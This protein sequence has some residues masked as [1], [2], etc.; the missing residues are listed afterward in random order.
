MRTPRKSWLYAAAV[1]MALC[2][3]AGAQALAQDT[4]KIGILHSLSGTMAISE[5]ILKDLMLMQVAELN[6]KGGLLGKKVEAGRCRSRLE[7]AAVRREGARAPHQG[8]GRR[9][10]RLLDLGLAQIRAA[11]VRGAQRPAVLP[12]RIRGRRGLLQ[13]LLRQLRSGQQGDPRGRI[14][15][16]QGR[17]RGEALR[18]RRHRLRLSA[19]QQQDHPRLPEERRASRTK[20]SWR[21]TRRSASPTGRPRSRRSRSSARPARRPRWSRPSTAMPTC[22]STRSSATRASRRRTFR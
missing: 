12:A 3:T 22:R 20:T 18:A 19:H 10:V 13:H 6:A 9:R 4:I 11:G 7:L 5:T 14:S 16:E 21:T 8:Q 17:R 15:D 2:A 1:S